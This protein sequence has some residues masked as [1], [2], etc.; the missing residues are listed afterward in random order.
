MEWS[1]IKDRHYGEIG[2]VICNGPSLKKVPVDFL[3]QYISIGTNGIFMLP[4]QP[5][6]Y[7]AINELAIRQFSKGIKEHIHCPR[8]IKQKYAQKLDALPLVSDYRGCTFSL[9][10]DKWVYEGGTVTYVA[11]QIAYYMGFKEILIV[12]LDH[13]YQA[14]GNPNEEVI[15]ETE[16][17]NHFT[18][19][20]FQLGKKWNLPD[21]SSSEISYREARRVFEADDRTITNL[22]EGTHEDIFEKGFIEVDAQDEEIPD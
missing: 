17:P 12:G 20:Y 22:T 8:F 18:T 16:D 11:L 7:V 2:L 13:Y 10:P 4:F 6:Y 21:L 15:M 14:V 3:S 9:E 1:D 5:S 19:N